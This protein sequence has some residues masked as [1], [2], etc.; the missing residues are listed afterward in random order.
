M[1]EAKRAVAGVPDSKGKGVDFL[2]ELERERERWH[3]RLLTAIRPICTLLSLAGLVVVLFMMVQ[4]QRL[5]LLTGLSVL[6]LASILPGIRTRTRALL[7]PLSLA[8]MCI[9]GIP[10]LGLAPNLFNGLLVSIAVSMLLLDRRRAVVICGVIAAGLIAMAVAMMTGVFSVS[11]RWLLEMDVRRPVNAIRVLIFFFLA[12]GVLAVSIAHV[13]RQMQRLLFEKSLALQSL[14]AEVAAKAELKRELEAKEKIEARARE[15]ELL[16]RLTSYFGHDT[17][18]ALLV[19][20]SSL[21]V[22]R[23]PAAPPRRKSEALSALGEAAT[24]IRDISSQLRAF[25]PGRGSAFGRSSNRAHLPRVFRGSERLLKQILPDTVTVA[26]GPVAEVHVAIDA[27]ELQRILTNL[28]LNARDA[29]RDRGTL[30]IETRLL[31][32]AELTTMALH[33]KSAV[34]IY[35][36]DTGAGI[37]RE[38]RERIF[39]PFFTTKGA[40]GSGLGLSSVKQSVEAC[41]GRVIVNSQ[42]GLGTTFT[43]AIPL[44]LTA[45]EERSR[46]REMPVS[47]GAVLV[48]EEPLVRQAIMRALRSQALVA[49]EAAS[50]D[51]GIAFLD[52]NEGDI[53]LLLV[54]DLGNDEVRDLV[55][56]FQRK[57]PG[58]RVVYCGD[59]ALED[60]R[61]R[62]SVVNLPKPF[63]LPELLKVVEHE[64]ALGSSGTG[65]SE[66][67]PPSDDVVRPAD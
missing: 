23:D 10:S 61:I 50:T 2:D 4:R 52:R 24:Q 53:A 22:L 43:L 9:L 25:G 31:S 29:M 63:T 37:P 17:N 47:G 11:P 58:G 55:V 14:R 60:E 36:A 57:C 20:W 7:L 16:G 6:L 15:L 59:G 12:S 44:A 67:S 34:A 42:E 40:K 28:A 51:E 38:L 56:A 39:E 30:S 26:I 65:R 62:V 45:S 19:V 32:T 3:A 46:T 5:L 35:V 13:L 66:E 48:V 27:S 1:S 33:A 64:I 54:G 41:G 49:H 8:A 21:D 18:N